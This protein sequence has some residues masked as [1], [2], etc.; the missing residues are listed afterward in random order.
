MGKRLFYPLHTEALAM[1]AR[2][3]P[4][5]FGDESKDNQVM[6]T[7]FEKLPSESIDLIFADPPY[8]IGK[9]L[10]GWWNPG[11][12]RLSGLAVRVH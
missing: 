1:N 8:N 11:M 9:T 3:E 2:C 7:E 6:L 5:Y 12:K 10:T 4:V